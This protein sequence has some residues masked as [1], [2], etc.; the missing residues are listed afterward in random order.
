MNIDL[1]LVQHILS[2][3]LEMNHIPNNNNNNNNNNKT[4]TQKY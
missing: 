2:L 1:I 3:C 4:I